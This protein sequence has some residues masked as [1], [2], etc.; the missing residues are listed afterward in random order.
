MLRRILVLASPFAFT[1]VFACSSD[2]TQV[3]PSPDAGSEG[4]AD[5]VDF[6][7]YAVDGVGRQ[8]W[9]PV[10]GASAFL[11]TAGGQRIE[12]TSDDSGQIVF[13]GVSFKD[14]PASITVY[15]SGRVMMTLVGVT[16][17]LVAKLPLPVAEFPAAGKNISFD[18]EPVTAAAAAESVKLTG[19][20]N[21]KLDAANIVTLSASPSGGSF[22]QDSAATYSLDVPKGQ[23]VKLVAMEWTKVTMTSTAW[24]ETKQRW[25]AYDV[26]A[27]S[28]DGT[29]DIDLAAGTTLTPTKVNVTLKLPDASRLG[30][31]PGWQI[32]STTFGSAWFLGSRSKVAVKADDPNAF[33]AEGEYVTVDAPTET[34]FTLAY[35]PGLDGEAAV[36]QQPGPPADG[37]VI[38][39]LA[40]PAALT[41]VAV[42]AEVALP[43][44]DASA[45]AA[46]IAVVD[47]KVVG[48]VGQDTPAWNVGNLR[49]ASLASIKLPDLP[50]AA[51]ALLPATPQARLSVLSGIF[52]AAHPLIPQK[53]A[54]S[55]FFKVA[56]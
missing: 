4:G 39:A 25:R 9:S 55:K 2:D 24:E 29:F 35:F 17:E 22:F 36:V 32:N 34:P 41:G 15:K 53:I 51:R 12:A 26:P 38:E 13:K 21:G 6:T 37:A 19:M 20:L 3:T 27:Q 52:D 56:K 47:H 8:K 42:G 46:N 40:Y 54:F 45:L 43:Q 48:G 7:V 23:P 44:L 1:V 50:D 31:A 30:T 49:G 28:A 14:G 16:P 18:I 5:V 33:T 10:G 11:D